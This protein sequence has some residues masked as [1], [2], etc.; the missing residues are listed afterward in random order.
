VLRAVLEANVYVSAYLRP[1]GAPGQIIERFLRDA[2]FELVVS[3]EITAEVL[4]ALAYPKA[5]RPPDRELTPSSGS[6]TSSWR[7]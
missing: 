3:A 7:R 2:A 6:R 4:H 5:G 1:E